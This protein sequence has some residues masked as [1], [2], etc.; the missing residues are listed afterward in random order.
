MDQN[1]ALDECMI[2]YFGRHGCNQCIRNKRV[3]FGFKAWCFTSRLEYLSTFDVYQGSSFGIIE[4]YESQ[5]GKGRNSFAP[6]W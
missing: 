1:L 6:S 3:R 5:F 2:E 4:N